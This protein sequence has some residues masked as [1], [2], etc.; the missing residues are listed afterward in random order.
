MLVKFSKNLY[1][2]RK[3]W[4]HWSQSRLSDTSGNDC[5][6]KGKSLVNTYFNW[7][8][9]MDVNIQ[10]HTWKRYYCS[11][12]T[13]S[14]DWKSK[15]QHSKNL[16]GYYHIIKRQCTKSWLWSAMIH[17]KGTTKWGETLHD[18]SNNGCI[19]DCQP[20]QDP[21][22][23]SCQWYCWWLAWYFKLSKKV[24]KLFQK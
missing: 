13:V 22:R 21:D 8:V 14:W 17:I 19:G 11:S 23:W 20:P 2:C 6:I 12:F 16:N 5:S 4:I 18:D 3:S 1:F 7:K 24:K 10:R 15:G 9:K